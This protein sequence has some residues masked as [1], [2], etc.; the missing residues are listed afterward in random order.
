M[1]STTAIP[2]RTRRPLP[3][4]PVKWGIAIVVLAVAAIF[5]YRFWHEASLFEAT[6]NAYVNANQV[7]IAA[8][9]S[10]AVTSV[11]V[12]DQQRVRAGDPL[13]EIDSAPYQLA[14]DRARAQLELQRLVDFKARR[15]MLTHMNPTM[16]AKVDEAKALGVLVAEDGL[17]LDL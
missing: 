17:V 4:K 6:D 14:L 11:H 10:G 9:V 13:F 8:Q 1:A 16:L 3:R 2:A 5:A 7:E 12:R 15:V